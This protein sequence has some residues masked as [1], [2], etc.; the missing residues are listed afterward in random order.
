[1]S[2]DII[3]QQTTFAAE[4]SAP[5]APRGT[6]FTLSRAAREL[7]LERSAVDLAVLLGLIATVQD[8]GGSRRVDPAEVERLR[9]EPAFPESLLE[10]V[11][12]VGT[13]E[14][15]ALLKV[16]TAR[17]T[18]LARLGAVVPVAFRLNRYR[19]VVWR[20]LA[21]DL[22]RF[23]ADAQHAPLLG[24]PLPEGLRG[25][26]DAGLDLRPR[27]W[28]G[29]HMALLLRQADDPWERAAV[30]A[31]L[32]G[33]AQV[34]ELVQDPWERAHLDR[35]RPLPRPQGAPRSPAARLAG[36]LMTAHDPDEIERLRTDLEQALVKARAHRP[37]PRPAPRAARRREGTGPRALRRAGGAERARGP[38][39]APGAG[40]TLGRG[41]DPGRVR[42]VPTLRTVRMA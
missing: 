40:G 28:R 7:G 4:Q 8:G 32:L 34:A 33:Q 29:R 20:Y 11:E 10:Q 1:M 19:A 37:A 30:V 5:A 12:T 36:H 31:S 13:K 24:E 16:T 21:E 26:L 6:P 18:R 42:T 38:R 9:A 39:K 27:N 25:Q 17:F 3:T 35:F 41:A 14:G 22:R 2:G 23:A 15:A